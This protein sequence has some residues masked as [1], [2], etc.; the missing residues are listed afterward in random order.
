MTPLINK[1]IGGRR[2]KTRDN[3]WRTKN[4]TQLYLVIPVIRWT[5][6]F[7]FDSSEIGRFSCVGFFSFPS[8]HFKFF[9][10]GDD[11]LPSEYDV[12]VVGTGMAESIVAAAAARIG[13][14]VLH[15]DGNDYYGGMWA[16]F[17][18]ECLQKWLDECRTTPVEQPLTN[19][20][21]SLAGPGENVISIGSPFSTVSN[22]EEEWFVPEN[23]PEVAPTGEGG[24]APATPPVWSKAHLI[25]LNRKFNLDLAPKLLFA[26]GS[27]VELLISSNIARYAEF[28]SVTRVLTWIDDKLEFVPC[29]RSDVFK[30]KDVSIVEKRLLMKLL[31]ICV[32][33]KED[34]NEFAGFEDKKFI[35][36]LKSKELTDNLMHYVLYAIAMSS[37]S[38]PCMEAVDRTKRF[39][40]SL[41]R[42]GNTPFLHPM[43]G[44]G[45]L[46]QCFC[47]LCAVYGGVYHL[48]RAADGVLI[49]GGETC[50]G[51][52][53][54]KQRLGTKHL[55]IGVPNAPSSFLKSIPK[56]GMS[57]GM[58]ITDRSILTSEKES[59]SLLQFPASNP[60]TI[61]ELG[62]ST[63]ACPSGLF[64]VHMTCKQELTAKEDLKTTVEK[65]LNCA[66]YDGVTKTDGSDT[67]AQV[68]YA[69]YFNVPDTS[70]CD[71]SSSVPQNVH[72]C[73]GPD[74]DL[75]FDFAVNQA[76]EIFTKMYPG[77]EFLPRAP[78]A[79]EIVTDDNAEVGP[80]FEADTSDTTAE[81]GP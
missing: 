36:Y 62:P 32:E 53:S 20:T 25:S 17:N 1:L 79:D 74:L 51:I 75:D 46:P 45:E 16:S 15:L 73:S 4:H 8:V 30:T 28:R 68:L 49:D 33:Y 71:L 23:S 37:T 81:T 29:S 21:A 6:N 11:D 24:D 39:L 38:T 58:F 19:E 22:I 72:L 12:I 43:Y 56:K 41:G 77:E 65:L 10:M 57:R 26:R 78:D 31:S 9:I 70:H 42:Y 59:L 80:A 14:K 40:A 64:V 55:V 60:I 3:C 48:K 76:K 7:P 61:I 50:K 35:D 34:N 27:L 2:R 5:D 13:K 18:L 52:V 54:T 66:P 47:R 67:R 69:L 63:H 44:S